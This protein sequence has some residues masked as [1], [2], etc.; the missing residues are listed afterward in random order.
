MT[1]N[2]EGQNIF[3]I[4]HAAGRMLRHELIK[5]LQLHMEALQSIE[6]D[7]FKDLMEREA[8][9][10]EENFLAL[11]KEENLSSAPKVP[12]FDFTPTI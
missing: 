7:E 2:E 8:M 10:L 11:F 9:A 3:V 4:N 1:Q 6:L 5:E 12:V